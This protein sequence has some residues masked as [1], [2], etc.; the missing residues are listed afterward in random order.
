MK[1]IIPNAVTVLRIAGVIALVALPIALDY[2]FIV[3]AA[4][5]ALD[6][7]DGFLAK[8]LNAKTVLGFRLDHIASI[9]FI[10]LLSLKFISSTEVPYWAVFTLAGIAVV[11]CASLVFGAVRFKK[12]AFINSDWNKAAKVTFYLIPLW[13]MFAGMIFACVVVIAVMLVATVEELVINLTSKEYNPDVK[14][15]IPL[16]KLFKKKRKK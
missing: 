14:T 2:Y 6:Y 15:I 5:A 9:L 13:Y 16:K 12:P 10:V 7:V 8:K 1:Q 11:K 3:F 4:C